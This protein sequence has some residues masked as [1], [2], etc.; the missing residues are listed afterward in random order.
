MDTQLL[1]FIVLETYVIFLPT[2][3]NTGIKKFQ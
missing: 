3:S 1:A 2:N